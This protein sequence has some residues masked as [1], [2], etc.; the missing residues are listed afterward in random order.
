MNTRLIPKYQSMT[1]SEYVSGMRAA[2]NT[3]GG[4]KFSRNSNCQRT[5][6]AV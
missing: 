3:H 1:T 6:L 4:P 2:S 5:N